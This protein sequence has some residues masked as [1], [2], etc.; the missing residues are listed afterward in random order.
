MPKLRNTKQVGV[1]W[2][3]AKTCYW[4]SLQI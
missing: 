1:P 4:S 2:S 3:L